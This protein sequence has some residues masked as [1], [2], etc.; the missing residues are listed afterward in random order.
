MKLL[1]IFTRL[2]KLFKN[3]NAL[4]IRI[5]TLDHRPR[6]RIIYTLPRENNL[7]EGFPVP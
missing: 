2:K 3:E 5:Q 6:A 1:L 4:K 7:K